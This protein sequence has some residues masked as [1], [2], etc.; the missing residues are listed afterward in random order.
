MAMIRK[1]IYLEPELDREIKREA[2]RRKMSAAALI[3]E[4]LRANGRGSGRPQILDPVPD[5][6]AKRRLAE[7]LRKVR[8]EAEKHGAG[9]GWKFNREDA[10]AERLA[11]LPPH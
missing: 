9:S 7:M 3:R 11:K 4:R 10:Y 1:Q 2:K 6:E 5:P 8:C